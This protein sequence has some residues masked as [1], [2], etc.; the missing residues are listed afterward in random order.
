VPGLERPPRLEEADE[1]P[2]VDAVAD[3]REQRGRGRPD[4]LLMTNHHPCHLC[5]RSNIR[6]HGS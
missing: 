6:D 3:D 1:S 5:P 4:A 2:V